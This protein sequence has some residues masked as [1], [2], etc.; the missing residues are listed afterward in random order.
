MTKNAAVRL[1]NQGRAW[2]E[3]GRAAPLPH[4]GGLW[5]PSL[6]QW[7]S[8]RAAARR[9]QQLRQQ[10]WERGRHAGRGRQDSSWQRQKVAAVG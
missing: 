1:L 7:S 9:R 6:Q 3:R 2:R 10:Q 8:E 5:Q 4:T